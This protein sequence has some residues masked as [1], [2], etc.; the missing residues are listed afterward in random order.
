MNTREQ[1]QQHNS[2]IS[3]PKKTE[4]M[5]A[6]EIKRKPTQTNAYVEK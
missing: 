2:H 1:K 5:N 3:T 6:D 4:R